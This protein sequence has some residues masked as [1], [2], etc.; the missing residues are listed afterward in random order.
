MGIGIQIYWLVV[1]SL[2]VACIA[3][4]VTQEKIFEEPRNFAKKK[5]ESAKSI[6]VRKFVT[7]GR[8]STALAIG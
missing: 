3:W 4:T 7:F 2:S 8:V 1:L 6:F 5:S